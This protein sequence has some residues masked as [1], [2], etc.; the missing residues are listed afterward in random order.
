MLG[1]LWN[2]SYSSSAVS[3][4]KTAVK[5]ALQVWV[6]YCSL[7]IL[8]ELGGSFLFTHSAIDVWSLGREF[9]YC[10]IVMAFFRFAYGRIG[11]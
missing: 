4:D 10:A 2:R 11:Y 5:I 7:R 9:W 6:D 3:D 8:M 1:A